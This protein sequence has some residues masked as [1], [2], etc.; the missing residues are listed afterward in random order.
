MIS[1]KHHQGP[2]RLNSK[3]RTHVLTFAVW[4]AI[5][6]TPALIASPAL[7]AQTYQV[8]HSFNSATEGALPNGLTRDAAG[9]FFGTT[10][11]GG[12][13]GLGTVFKLDS[14]HVFTVLHTFS[15]TP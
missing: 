14:A 12:S 8:I 1:K 9:N 5:M 15:G 6:L 3:L 10:R 13:T 11:Q 7:H 2:G 4:S